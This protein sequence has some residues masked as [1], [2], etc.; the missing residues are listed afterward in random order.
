MALAEIRALI[1]IRIY[2]GKR[3]GAAPEA[4]I[5]EGRRRK[6]TRKRNRQKCRNSGDPNQC[7]ELCSAASE[8]TLKHN[9]T[10]NGHARGRGFSVRAGWCRPQPPGRSSAGCL[11]ALSPERSLPT[12]SDAAHCGF[13]RM[14]PAR[15]RV[16]GIV[17]RRAGWPE[18][19][20]KLEI[21]PYAFMQRLI[22][23]IPHMRP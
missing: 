22:L 1:S 9:S 13:W 20:L 2:R 10:C 6:G 14:A 16:G 18:R 8:H 12:S 7:Y 23:K 21:D 5:S 3:S 17:V 15:A 4:R 19:F 11:W